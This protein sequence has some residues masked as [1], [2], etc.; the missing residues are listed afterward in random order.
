MIYN[1][2]YTKEEFIKFLEKINVDNQIINKFTKLPEVIYKNN[3]KY[4]LYIDSTYYIVDKYNTFELNYYCELLIEF[5][6]NSKIFIDLE[7]SINNLSY[8]LL[9]A[10]LI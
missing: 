1:K 7:L 10:K 3:N 8:E 5:L 4:E 6:F 9:N 2:K